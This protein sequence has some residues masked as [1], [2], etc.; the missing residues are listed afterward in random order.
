MNILVLGGGG[1]EHALC[2]AISKSK[3]CQKLYCIPG[4]AGIDEI[5]QCFN[6]CLKKK[7]N[8][9]DF[10]L[11]KNIDFVVIGPE[12]YLERGFSD[13]LI[14]NNINV[15][16]PS[17]EA[18]KLETSKTFSKN[19]LQKNNIPTAKFKVFFNY[20]KAK[21]FIDLAKPPFVIKADGLAAGKGVIICKSRKS[22]YFTIKEIFIKK[23][24]GDAG[25]KILIEEF[26]TGFEFSYFVFFDKNN[27]LKLGYALDHKRV[28]D[29]DKG[30]NTG[31]MGAFTPSKKISS[32]M[33]KNVVEKIIK[34]TQNGLRKEK[35]IYRG[36]L[37]FG[38][39]ICDDGPKVIEYNVRFGDPECQTILRNFNSDF[40][41]ILLNTSRDELGK[42]QSIKIDKCFSICVILA[43]KGYPKKY[44]NNFIL[45]RLKNAEKINGIKVFHCGTKLENKKL[46]SNGGRVMAITSKNKN[47]KKARENAYKAIKIIN[48]K[49]GI[50]RTDI[51]LKNI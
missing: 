9:L 44:K 12:E 14:K 34:P 39:M 48:W 17:K 40:L 49:Q 35:I 46:L 41:Q 37:F 38:I 29:N 31:G 45:S 50:Y 33:I 13:Y 32:K 28:K 30:L 24:F 19:F 10:C 6:I 7:K 51:G 18:S 47:I 36:I 3:K 2:W 4:N 1:R 43:S 25:K 22:A 16:G 11:E 27:F 5:A 23:K 8:L 21:K 26:L 42:D 15:F 20:E